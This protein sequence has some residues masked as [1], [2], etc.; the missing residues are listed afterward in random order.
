M[1]FPLPSTN[2]IFIICI[3]VFCFSASTLS[4][5][6]YI[7][8]D[9]TDCDNN[10]KESSALG[11]FCN[12]LN[13]SCQAYLTF[14]STPPYNSVVAISYLLYAD[15]FGRT[16]NQTKFYVVQPVDIYWT[17]ANNTFQG[18]TTCQALI[19]Q[20]GNPPALDLETCQKITV[21]LRC[22]CPTK[23]Q[24]DVGVNYLMSYFTDVDDDYYTISQE[25]GVDSQLLL[26]ANR[27][28]YLDNTIYPDTTILV[29]LKS[30]PSN[31]QTIEPPPSS[32]P[33][34]L[35]PPTSSPSSSS[36]KENLA[37]CPA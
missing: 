29:P 27:L 3:I 9:N 32:L 6:P 5:Q 23:N 36:L 15:P 16:I 30:P 34:P 13:R 28:S 12:G 8:Q 10:H 20:T 11:Y 18:L 19:N 25:Y 2:S 14:R 33:P 37:L 24:I 31:S 26:Q 17:L 7:G 1:A 4:Q 22:A 35:Q 21:P